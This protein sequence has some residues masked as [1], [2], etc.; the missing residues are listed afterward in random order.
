MKRFYP[1]WPLALFDIVNFSDLDF[2]LGRVCVFDLGFTC[3]TM[4]AYMGL[5]LGIS[6]GFDFDFPPKFWCA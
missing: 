5:R 3:L 2:G 1:F 4:S 6:G